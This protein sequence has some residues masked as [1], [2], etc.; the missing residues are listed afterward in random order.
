MRRRIGRYIAVV[1]EG[2]VKVLDRFLDEAGRQAEAFYNP[3]QKIN[4]DLSVLAYRTF[5]KQRVDAGEQSCSYLDAFA[6]TGM[7]AMRVRKEV[8]RSLISRID[9][10]DVSR[11]AIEMMQRNLEL[12]EIED[13]GVVHNDAMVHL[14]QNRKHYDIIDVDPYGSA[15]KYLPTIFDC[16]KHNA[17]IGAT[18]TDLKVLEGP[19]YRRLYSLYGIERPASDACK[20]ERTV[21]YLLSSINREAMKHKKTI[22]PLLSVWK[23]FYVRLFFRVVNDSKACND[24]IGRMSTVLRCLDC[25]F[26]HRHQY[27]K[28]D[29]RQKLQL[30]TCISSLPCSRKFEIDGCIWSGPLNDREFVSRMKA[31]MQADDHE[32]ASVLDSILNE[33]DGHLYDM[34]QIF[35]SLNCTAASRKL[36]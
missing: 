21:R 13:I 35:S 4:R 14:L 8:D 12:N 30:D 18:Y 25:R 24:S 27:L 34:T 7:R 19:D 10:C 36:I 33:V 3:A 1:Q 20:E 5:S 23:N 9:A 22:E 29:R 26:E 6:A 28:E 17:M 32:V 15:Q 11:D 2:R 31:E 16:S